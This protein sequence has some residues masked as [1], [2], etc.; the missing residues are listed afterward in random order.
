MLSTTSD[1]ALEALEHEAGLRVKDSPR[2]GGSLLQVVCSFALR[3]TCPHRRCALCSYTLTAAP[4]LPQLVYDDMERQAAA[5]GEEDAASRRRQ[6]EEEL[7][8]GGAAASP[9][10]CPSRLQRS[11]E[12]LHDSNIICIACCP[13][14]RQAVTGS[15]N[16]VITVLGYDG[17]LVRR[18]A[19]ATTG[20]LCL[21][22]QADASGSGSG[23][24]GGSGSG[25][26]GGPSSTSSSSLVAA[27]CMDGSVVVADAAAGAVLASAQPHRKYVVAAA[28]SPDGA[29]LVTASWDHSFAVHH[30]RRR[31]PAAA[32]AAGQEAA[33]GG[34]GGGGQRR[35]WELVTVHSVPTAAKVNAVQFLPSSASD[36]STATSTFLVAVQGSN[37]LR[38]LAI[39]PPPTFTTG[40]TAL[41]QE[42]RINMNPRGDDHVSFSAAHLALSP[43]ARLLLVSADN[44][45]LLVYERE[46]EPGRGRGVAGVWL[47]IGDPGWATPWLRLMRRPGEAAPWPAGAA[48]AGGNGGQPWPGLLPI[49]S[50]RAAPLYRSAGWTQLRFMVGLPIEQFHHFCAAFDA[51][52]TH[53]MAGGAPRPAPPARSPVPGRPPTLHCCLP[54]AAWP[55]AQCS[56][57][58]RGVANRHLTPC[59]PPRV[60]LCPGPAAA[61][62]GGLAIFHVG[63]AKRVALLPAHARNVRGLAVDGAANL[64]LTC[65]FDRTVKVWEAEEAG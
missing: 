33:G 52:G 43:C 59:A 38:Q 22:L 4:A 54:P 5:G 65:S 30:L 6:L 25:G 62:H 2:L 37:Y 11:I 39:A 1:A 26:G 42:P 58:T 23:N 14:R 10:R 16:G 60:P 19:A 35:E 8:S 3:D 13:C 36:A 7:L 51:S 55:P 46:G 18:I 9:G 40:A 32:A 41:R 17:T 31:D 48:I 50:P 45:R 64:L 27:G 61:A 29:H 15:S 28:F 20:L 49:A 24:G 12:G 21:A 57:A 34:S 53:V 56:A 63:S 44:G 47:G